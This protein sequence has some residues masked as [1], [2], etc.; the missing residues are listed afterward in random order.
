MREACLLLQKW[1]ESD[2][3]KPSDISKAEMTLLAYAVKVVGKDLIVEVDSQEEE[4]MNKILELDYVLLILPAIPIV[5]W[6]V[7]AIV[8]PNETKEEEEVVAE[9]EDQ[10]K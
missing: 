2:Q 7:F 10:K 9:K 5:I 1:A 8:N 4:I 3:R 6:W